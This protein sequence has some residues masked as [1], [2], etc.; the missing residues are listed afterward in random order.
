MLV[1]AFLSMWISNT[2]TTAMMV[3]IAEA[4]LSQLKA[5]R[6]R[7]EQD[8]QNRKRRNQNIENIACD[9]VDNIDVRMEMKE[10]EANGEEIRPSG[11]QDGMANNN[12][13]EED[14]GRLE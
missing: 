13:K 4:V 14:A 7:H 2:A 6:L 12:R 11:N 1:T 9:A 3:P 5:E 10:R 8:V